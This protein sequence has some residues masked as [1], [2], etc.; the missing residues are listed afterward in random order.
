MS[1]RLRVLAGTLPVIVAVAVVVLVEDPFGGAGKPGGVADNAT[2][3]S[4]ATVTRRPL[5]SQTQV[6][7]TLGYA[8]ESSIRVP[9]GTPPATVRQAEQAVTIGAGMLRT[10]RA[11]LSADSE[12][13]AGLRASLSA[14][15]QKETVDCSGDS[16]A[17]S[18]SAGSS[19]GGEGAPGA[20]PSGGSSGPCASDAQA[21]STAEQVS[22]GD[23][24]KLQSDSASVSSAETALAGAE[25]ASSSAQ[26]SVAAYAQSS[27][28]TMLPAVGQVVSRGQ[29]LYQIS[30][31]PVVL[32][33]GSLLPSR[34]FIAG[35]PAGRDV[36]ELNANMDAL[37]YGRGLTGEAF[38]ASTTAAIRSFQSAHGLPATGSLP[39]G[40][41]VFEPGPVRVTSVTATLGANVAPGPVLAITSTVP[42]VTI[43]LAAAEQSSVKVGDQVEITLPNNQ[44]TPGVVKAVG[45]VAKAPSTGGEG[46]GGEGGEESAPTIG[47]DVTPSDPGAIGHLDQAPVTAS[48]T[49]ATIPSALVV[50]VDA[51]LALAGGG[52]A[53]EVAEG[54]VHHLVAVTLGL[55]DDAE[56][57]V[58]VSGQ[59]LSVGERVVVP[60]S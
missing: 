42:E 14:A 22:S 50:P 43:E 54:G 37:G 55:F 15:R 35:M 4:L 28:F 11:S 27:T 3:V 6:G 20:S 25:A 49:T 47:V 24:S 32:L 2:A 59:G 33:Y 57:L 21:V 23:A 38:S 46:K 7:A 41:V 60:A 29:A 39:L 18:A 5:S 56:G 10:A 34:A 36:A 45:T 16:A 1:A 17:E 31:Q 19:P 26:S 12:T 44:T 40:S 52:D 8:S 30:G 53:V 48:I 51:L 58:Q 9:A 13:L